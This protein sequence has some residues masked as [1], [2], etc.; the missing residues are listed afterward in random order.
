MCPTIVGLGSRR[1]PKPWQFIHST[2]LLLFPTYTCPAASGGFCG[3]TCHTYW[4]RKEQPGYRRLGYL[5]RLHTGARLSLAVGPNG[6]VQCIS[7]RQDCRGVLGVSELLLITFI[8]KCK[9]IP[10]QAKEQLLLLA[11]SCLPGCHLAWFTMGTD[12]VAGHLW[13]TALHCLLQHTKR[14]W[15]CKLSPQ[16]FLFFQP[17]PPKTPTNRKSKAWG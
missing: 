10:L 6:C 7:Y 13:V 5:L 9:G 17:R 4:W 2:F 3:K 11:L 15:K 14:V 1:L 16:L 8:H 12:C